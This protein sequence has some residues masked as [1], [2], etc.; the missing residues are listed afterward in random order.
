MQ[1]NRIRPAKVLIT[2][3]LFAAALF[4]QY[5]VKLN[6][7]IKNVSPIIVLPLLTAFSIFGTPGAAASAGLI[8]GICMDALSGGA[9]CFNAISL[10]LFSVFTAALSNN[11]FNRN[12]SSAILISL[13]VSI[14]Y[15][16]VRW[17]IFYAPQLDIHE[18]STYLL[19]FALPSLLYTNV[20]IF[21]FYFIYRHF[22]EPYER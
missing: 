6:I 18:N 21:P 17:L 11:L 20:F 1:K 8:T 3:L 13:I 9:Y 12:I 10:M 15:F 5:T 22:Y 7:S 14:L 4:I 2:V 16:A 19:S